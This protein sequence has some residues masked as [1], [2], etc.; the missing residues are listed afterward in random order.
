[1][2]RERPTSVGADAEDAGAL[3]DGEVDV[4]QGWL[5]GIGEGELLDVNREQL[6]CS[7]IGHRV[8]VEEE[9]NEVE[10]IGR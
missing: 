5:V 4:V 10:R 7:R 2:K 1:M 3:G 6:S 8:S 9:R